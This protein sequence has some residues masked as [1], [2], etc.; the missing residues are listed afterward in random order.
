MVQ[1]DEDFIATGSNDRTVKIYRYRVY[2]LYKEVAFKSDITSL[3]VQI[4]KDGSS[5]LLVGL[6]KD[7]AILN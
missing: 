4:R 3:A 5:F 2:E 6:F 7:V 1:V